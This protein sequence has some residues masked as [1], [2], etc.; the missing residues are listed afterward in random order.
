[1][2][3]GYFLAQQIVA[4]QWLHIYSANSQKVTFYDFCLTFDPQ[5]SLRQH[6]PNFIFSEMQAAVLRYTKWSENTMGACW[7]I[8]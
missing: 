2:A 1:M 5:K 4:T 3:P 7:R 8:K 6:G